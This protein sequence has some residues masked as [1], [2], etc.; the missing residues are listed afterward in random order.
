MRIVAATDM[1]ILKMGWRAKISYLKKKIE[2]IDLVMNEA[3][4]QNV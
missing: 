2:Q 1:K 3:Q 4:V